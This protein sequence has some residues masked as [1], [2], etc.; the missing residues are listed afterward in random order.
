MLSIPQRLHGNNIFEL[1]IR[2]L[3]LEFLSKKESLEN[4]VNCNKY[5]NIITY[6]FK[7]ANQ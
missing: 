2:C 3:V 5:F 4:L 7:N 1:V 6:K